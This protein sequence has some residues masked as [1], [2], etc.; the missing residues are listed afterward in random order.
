MVF[1]SLIRAHTVHAHVQLP[2]SPTFPRQDRNRFP[3]LSRMTMQGR[4]TEAQA[5][6]SILCPPKFPNHIRLEHEG[7]TL[8]LLVTTV[9]KRSASCPIQI[10]V[11]SPERCDAEIQS[12]FE[13]TWTKRRAG[14][15]RPWDRLTRRRL[16][17]RSLPATWISHPQQ[18]HAQDPRELFPKLQEAPSRNRCDQD[19]KT[20]RQTALSPTP[21]NSFASPQGDVQVARGEC[22]ASCRR[23]VHVGF[24][25]WSGV[26]VVGFLGISASSM[27]RGKG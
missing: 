26:F 4:G 17:E 10:K 9:E 21:S 27:T 12:I 13:S 19:I 2:P 11:E 20:P 18:N 15:W 6:P 5:R 25:D 24:V 1:C 8:G 23:I 14:I 22:E 16:V 7:G 3:G